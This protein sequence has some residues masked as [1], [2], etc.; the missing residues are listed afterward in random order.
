MWHNP[1]IPQETREQ[2]HGRYSF[3]EAGLSFATA[4]VLNAVKQQISPIYLD[5]IG[6]LELR[7][8]GFADLLRRALAAGPDLVLAVRDI[9][10]QSVARQFGIDDY[11]LVEV[12]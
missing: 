2:R 10:V 3:G 5:E 4:I 1:R 7:G 12:S 11:R 8:S 9:N 6:K